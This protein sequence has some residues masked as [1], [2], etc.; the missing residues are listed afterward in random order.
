MLL[1]ISAARWCGL[2]MPVEPCRSESGLAFASAA[3]SFTFLAG[4]EGWHTTMPGT[5]AKLVMWTKSLEQIEVQ[6]RVAGSG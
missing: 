1:K 5:F 2:P 4:S 3:S 6:L